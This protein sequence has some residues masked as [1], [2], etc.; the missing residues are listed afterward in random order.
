M[1]YVIE[2]NVPLPASRGKYPFREMKVGDSF[3]AEEKVRGAAQAFSSRVEGFK[4]LVRKEG[5]K[6]R[7]WRT[8]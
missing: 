3:V 6:V 5:D 8:A 7:I 2:K 1:S 4:F